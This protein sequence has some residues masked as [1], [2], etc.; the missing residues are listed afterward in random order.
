LEI[1]IEEVSGPDK[2][3]LYH[4]SRASGC[5]IWTR[6]NVIHIGTDLFLGFC[7]L[8]LFRAVI[9]KQLTSLL[10]KLCSLFFSVFPLLDVPAL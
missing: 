5:I 8:Q 3:G 4:Q 1:A 6:L 2:D 10:M 7:F 9:S